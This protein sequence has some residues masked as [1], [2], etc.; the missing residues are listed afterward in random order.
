MQ[1]TDHLNVELQ[2]IVDKNATINQ[3]G[4]GYAALMI[5]DMLT[6]LGVKHKI[7]GLEA[8]LNWALNNPFPDLRT[9]IKHYEAKSYDAAL[10]QWCKWYTE[11]DH[12]HLVSPLFNHIVIKI[13]GKLFDANGWVRGGWVQ[14]GTITR[15][16]LLSMVRMR[17]L[18]NPTWQRKPGSVQ[19]IVAEIE[20][21]LQKEVD[22]AQ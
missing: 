12:G 17:S 3:G 20:A 9:E 13:D 16:T 21:V 4:C 22:V 18:W 5:S 11:D 7:V 2:R 1:I 19:S 14:K 6:R 15:D 10:R 8:P